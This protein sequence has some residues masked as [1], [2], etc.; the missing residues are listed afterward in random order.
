MTFVIL[1]R[2]KGLIFVILLRSKG[3][4]FCGFAEE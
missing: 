1:L 2:N 3:Y 4:D